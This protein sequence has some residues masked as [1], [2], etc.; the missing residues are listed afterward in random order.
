MAGPA[1]F[2]ENVFYPLCHN[3]GFFRSVVVVSG[4]VE[5]PMNEEIQDHFFIAVPEFD[6]VIRSP[7]RTNYHVSQ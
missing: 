5:N 4:K 2:V 6:R 3:C 1:Q 7:V